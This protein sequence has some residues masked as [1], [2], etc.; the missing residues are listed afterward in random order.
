MNEYESDNGV[1]YSFGYDTI[2]A[3][4]KGV[5]I[6]KDESYK[7]LTYG[8]ESELEALTDL[9]PLYRGKELFELLSDD[10]A[11][12]DYLKDLFINTLSS[13]S[14]IT[15]GGANLLNSLLEEGDYYNFFRVVVN[16]PFRND[17]PITVEKLDT[18][19]LPMRMVERDEMWQQ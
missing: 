1:S 12:A 16:N 6:A 18:L 19:L 11:Y 5:A 14:T 4:M 17:L 2:G 8:S 10:E 15:D 7:D 13:R 9:V 3:Y